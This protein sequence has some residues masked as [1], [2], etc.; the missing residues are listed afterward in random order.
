MGRPMGPPPS[1]STASTSTTDSSTDTTASAT[2]STDPTTAALLARKLV[3]AMSAYME[4]SQSSSA[5][6]SANPLGIG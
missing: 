6:D 1:S 5:L 4:Q 2:D 3:T